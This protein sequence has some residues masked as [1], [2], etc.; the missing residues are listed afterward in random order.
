MIHGMFMYRVDDLELGV[1]LENNGDKLYTSIYD[2]SRFLTFQNNH[3]F[4]AKQEW[5][6]SN[7][8]SL[9][10]DC[11]LN[12]YKIDLD[13]SKLLI[14]L[15][16]KFLCHDFDRTK[17]SS[18]VVDMVDESLDFI[19]EKGFKIYHTNSD[20]TLNRFFSNKN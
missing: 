5:F 12:H 19:K 3:T 2:F 6:F 8:K 16:N 7:I 17:Y 20:L 13:A 4:M 11:E 14:D 15:N 1:Y 18:K 10:K 9:S